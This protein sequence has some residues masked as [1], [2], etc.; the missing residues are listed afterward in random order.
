MTAPETVVVL[1]ALFALGMVAVL[2]VGLVRNGL[3]LVRA[4]TAFAKEATPVVDEIGA[5]A[6]RASRHM[7]RLSVAAASIRS[8]G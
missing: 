3:R 6:D 4:A 7:E 5:E 8:R 2:S 1:L